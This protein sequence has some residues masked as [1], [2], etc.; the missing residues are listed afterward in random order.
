MKLKKSKDFWITIGQSCRIIHTQY[1]IPIGDW[2]NT[3]VNEVPRREWVVVCNSFVAISRRGIFFFG[4][5]NFLEISVGA[6]SFGWE[7]LIEKRE[8]KRWREGRVRMG[9]TYYLASLE[10]KICWCGIKWNWLN[11]KMKWVHLVHFPSWT[12][13]KKKNRNKKDIL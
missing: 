3:D 12:K 11:V 5:R 2:L 10:V 13:L 9:E 7:G 6:I 8:R 4:N 1:R